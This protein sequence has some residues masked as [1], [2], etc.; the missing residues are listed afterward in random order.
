MEYVQ[1]LTLSPMKGVQTLDS[2][3]NLVHSGKKI[4][5]IKSLRFVFQSFLNIND[6]ALWS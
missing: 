6:I 1:Y 2:V 3:R 4:N 5:F